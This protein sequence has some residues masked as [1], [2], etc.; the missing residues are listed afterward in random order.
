[1]VR[2]W[3][4]PLLL[5]LLPLVHT[6]WVV[7]GT[8]VDVPYGDDW[9][10][11]PV[12]AALD[13]GRVPGELVAA[14]DVHRLLVPR[15]GLAAVAFATGWDTTWSLALT[16]AVAA[17]AA[18]LLGA[19]AVRTT[20]SPWGVPLASALVLSLV[21][22]ENWCWAW[23]LVIPTC[24][25]AS[26]AA[27]FAL[28]APAWRRVGAGFALAL[29]AAFSFASGLLL[30]PLGLALLLAPVP[31]PPGPDGQPAPDPLRARRL[32]LAGAWALGWLA[33]GL[34][35][36]SGLP[37]GADPPG[38]GRGAVYLLCWLGA[39]LTAGL[40]PPGK[41]GVVETGGTALLGLAALVGLGLLARR[42]V[43]DR[44]E[45]L[46]LRAWLALAGV[47]LGTGLLCALGRAASLGVEQ[48]RVSRYFAFSSLVWLA[49]SVA[50][51]RV[52][53]EPERRRR[54]RGLAA[55]VV[56]VV[57]GLT[58]L[59]ATRLAPGLLAARRAYLGRLA[60]RL[61]ETGQADL[62]S[63]CTPGAVAWVR[64]QGWSVFRDEPGLPPRGDVEAEGPT[65]R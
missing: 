19:R 34:P 62:G 8:E 31:P 15:L 54:E 29:V 28:E 38:V 11:V 9:E 18:A 53:A 57:V 47:G 17:A 10:M 16:L 32:P 41:A 2:R 22:Y 51:L 14:H 7:A 42:L 40:V 4:L 33:V 65:R 37:R 61:R 39:P 49:L 6:A 27:T 30:A 20:G 52:A 48:A 23:Q 3:A 46:A 63:A 35:Y 45:R 25:L 36:V 21:H 56:A 24:V 59:G 12:L 60:W 5:A 44:A 13:E 55:A 50:C 26:V 64:S 58:A 43:V 1:M